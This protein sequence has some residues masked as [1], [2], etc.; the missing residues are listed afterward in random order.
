DGRLGET[1]LLALLG[2]GAGGAENA[3]LNTLGEA[4]AALR[5]VGLDKDAQAV[6]VEAALAGGL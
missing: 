2:L 6:A 4:V 5:A 3:G 1:V